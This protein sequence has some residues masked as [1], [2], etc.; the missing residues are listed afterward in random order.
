MLRAVLPPLLLYAVERRNL[1][2]CAEHDAACLCFRK[3]I[4]RE[5]VGDLQ[6]CQAPCTVQCICSLGTWEW[7]ET[8]ALPWGG[9]GIIGLPLG[10][11][12][13]KLAHGPA[14]YPD[15]HCFH[16]S[17]L[18]YFIITVTEYFYL[19]KIDKW[20]ECFRCMKE[21]LLVLNAW[22]WMAGFAMSNRGTVQN[23]CIPGGWHLLQDC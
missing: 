9:W 8:W 13:G 17:Y 3:H 2:A 14:P 21:L 12:P 23:I 5:S 18:Q 1:I 15:G 7:Q 10:R 22:L 4:P 6:P 11:G 20:P 19:N 16:S